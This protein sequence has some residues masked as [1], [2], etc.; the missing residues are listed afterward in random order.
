[1]LRGLTTVSFFADDLAAARK[2]YSD[3]L[4]MEPYFERPGYFEFRVGDYQ[5]ELG[6][7]DSRY[8]PAVR[9]PIRL[10]QSFTGTSTT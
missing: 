4:G 3:L 2:W 8:A 7:I 9:R 5:H 1:M 10:V 6:V